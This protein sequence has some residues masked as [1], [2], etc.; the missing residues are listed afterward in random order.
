MNPQEDVD[1]S[2]PWCN[3][4]VTLVVECIDQEYTEDCPV[5]CAP[6][7]VRVVIPQFGMPQVEVDREGG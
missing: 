5:C 2:C 1:V 4:P 7:L 6:M 3:E